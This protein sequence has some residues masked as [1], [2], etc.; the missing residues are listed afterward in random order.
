MLGNDSGDKMKRKALVLG[1]TGQDGSFLCELLLSKGYDVHGIIRRSSSFNT[2]RID[3]IFSQLHLHFGDLTDGSSLSGLLSSIRPQEIYSIAAQSHVAVSFEIPEFTANSGA[4]GTLRLL[5]AARAHCPEARIYNA[6]SSEMFG[7]SPAPQN[8]ETAF[9]PRS[10]YACSKVF[11]HNLCINYREAYG[12]F[13]ANGILF[14]H[15]SPRRGLT[16]V[17]RKIAMAAARIS[18]GLQNELLLG[19]ILSQRDWGYAPEFVYAM[20]LML[21][22]DKPD[23]FVIATNETHTIEEF[24]QEAFGYVDLDWTK[25]VS[26]DA[27]YY[28]PAEVPVLRG[29]YSKA[30]RVLGWEPKVRFKE[31]VK[32]MMQAELEGLNGNNLSNCS[33]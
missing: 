11:S 31:L 26:R 6:S 4:M 3:H 29:D 9:H 14:N 21:Q 23:D 10:P 18:R 25:Y 33:N 7:T 13:C 19:N 2:G 27:K 1:A 28:R 8:E 24:L 17:T 12:M 30:Q 16:F 15:E 32:I 20:W 22:Q 5:E